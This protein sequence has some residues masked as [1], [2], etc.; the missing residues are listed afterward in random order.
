MKVG[1]FFVEL[2]VDGAAGQV[3]VRDLAQGFGALEAATLGQVGALVALGVKLAQIAD[4]AMTT[5]TAFQM[6]ETQ[7]GLSAQKLQTWQIAAEQAN[8]SAEAVAAGVSSL[9]RNLAAIRMGQG[10]IAPFQILGI[11]ANQDAFAVLDQLR[12]RLKTVNA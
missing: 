4:Q 6:F 8:V 9:E 1:E 12:D 3:T 11:G 7:T 5:A 10:N 2:L